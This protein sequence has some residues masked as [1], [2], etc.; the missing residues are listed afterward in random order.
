MT[1]TFFAKSQLVFREVGPLHTFWTSST[2]LSHILSE[3]KAN[4][5]EWSK[6]SHA[7]SICIDVWRYCS[8]VHCNIKRCGTGNTRETTDHGMRHRRK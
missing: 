6:S 5:S 2:I 1:W 3:W 4:N 8:V 7:C